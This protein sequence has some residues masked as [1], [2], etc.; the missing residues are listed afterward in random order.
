MARVKHNALHQYTAGLNNAPT[1]GTELNLPF[2]TPGFQGW[3][4]MY[5]SFADGI[6]H[7]GNNVKWN[8]TI[9]GSTPA[10]GIGA[11]GI[12]LPTIA[13]DNTGSHI[14]HTTPQI[15][16]GATTKKFYLE[17]SFTLT[18][19]TMASNEMLV[20]F[21]T[22]ATGD[23][24]QAAAGTSWTFDNGIAFGK[25]DTATELD[26]IARQ[27]DV[28]QVI[29]VGSTMTTAIRA[30]FGCYYDGANYLIYKDGALVARASGESVP[31]LVMGIS[32][33]I[34]SGTGAIQTLLVNYV[35]LGTEL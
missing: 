6:L 25:L 12:S 24:H 30:T 4:W 3:K 17:T 28:E 1:G 5:E 33:F 16:L 10:P 19:A 34:K 29:G 9:V 31:Q 7:T 27:A 20:G 21:T 23:T 15:I 2:P 32:L 22:D 13:T 18:A 35:A 26:F 8:E 14:Q 11:N